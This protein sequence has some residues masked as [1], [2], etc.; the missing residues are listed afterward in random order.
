M[1]ETWVE[2]SFATRV[3]THTSSVDR[4]VTSCPKD[5]SKEAEK[6]KMQDGRS[7]G[8]SIVRMTLEKIISI[9]SAYRQLHR[10]LSSDE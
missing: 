4:F 6:K 10:T 3:V 9:Q 7:K 5:T 8:E 2:F 1:A